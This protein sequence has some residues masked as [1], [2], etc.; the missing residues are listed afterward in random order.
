MC[1]EIHDVVSQSTFNSGRAVLDGVGPSVT[2][3]LLYAA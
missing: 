2:I 3:T 1:N